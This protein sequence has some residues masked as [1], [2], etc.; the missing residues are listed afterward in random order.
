MVAE[1]DQAQD[2]RNLHARLELAEAARRDH[3]SGLSRAEAEHGHRELARDDHHR[4]PGRDAV[5]RNERDQRRDDQ[6]LVRERVH[7][8]AERRDFF[9]RAREV[10]VREVG[11]G[12][13]GE[14]DGGEDVPIRRLPEQ[15]DDQDRHE[16]DPDN[17]Q[18]VGPVQRRHVRIIRSG[19]RWKC[20][21]PLGLAPCR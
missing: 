6:Q 21:R 4:H 8:L 2:R 17:R 15:R 3:H 5:Q 9:A 7:Q 11:R 16:Q 13:D 19:G 20:R 14:D 10:T 1:R 12:G 18:E